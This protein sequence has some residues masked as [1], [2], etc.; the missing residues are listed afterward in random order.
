MKVWK[1]L[2]KRIKFKIK[3]VRG[4]KYTN[5]L[6]SVLYCGDTFHP[7]DENY[8]L[9]SWGMDNLIHIQIHEPYTNP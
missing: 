5:Y 1:E 7:D 6:R 2:R 9:I 8:V 3:N 4:N